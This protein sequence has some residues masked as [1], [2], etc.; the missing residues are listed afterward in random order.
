MIVRLQLWTNHEYA[1]DSKWASPPWAFN[2]LSVSSV[3]YDDRPFAPW[4]SRC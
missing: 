1:E 2:T 4:A 3:E